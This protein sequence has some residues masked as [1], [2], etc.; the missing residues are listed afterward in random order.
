MVVVECVTHQ[1]WAITHT[2][3]LCVLQDTAVMDLF[4]EEPFATSPEEKTFHD[5]TTQGDFWQ[6][7]RGPLLSGLYVAGQRH[8]DT[9]RRGTHG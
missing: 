8:I 4:M 5:I 6:W 3:A 1:S 7:A 9:A 2:V